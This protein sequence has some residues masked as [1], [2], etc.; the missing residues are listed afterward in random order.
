MFTAKRIRS[1]P[2]LLLLAVALVGCGPPSLDSPE[3]GEIIERVPARLNKPYPLPE[4]EE[5]TVA[6]GPLPG[7]RPLPDSPDSPEPG[8]PGSEPTS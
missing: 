8:E 4:L 1:L 6:P 2:L 7:P 5:P 3:Y